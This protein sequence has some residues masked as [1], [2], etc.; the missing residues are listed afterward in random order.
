MTGSIIISLLVLLVFF[1]FY[2]SNF[3]VISMMNKLIDFNLTKSQDLDI[4]APPSDQNSS[5]NNSVDAAAQQ[6]MK[7]EFFE[8]VSDGLSDVENELEETKESHEII[9]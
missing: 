3:W 4:A 2:A 6:D 7:E 9:N 5:R 1:S 8:K